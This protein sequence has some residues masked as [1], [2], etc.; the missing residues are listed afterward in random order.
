[1]STGDHSGA[2]AEIALGDEEFIPDLFNVCDDNAKGCHLLT[3][4]AIDPC[5][6]LSITR[7]TPHIAPIPPCQPPMHTSAFTPVL[8]HNAVPTVLSP[9]TTSRIGSGEAI[10]SNP[11]LC[12]L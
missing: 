9:R 11:Q 6:S 2:F 3:T 1:M 10:L 7:F 8:S 5:L 12:L 4:Y